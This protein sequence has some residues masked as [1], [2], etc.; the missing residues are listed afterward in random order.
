ME[1]G[2]AEA[3]IQRLFV[4]LPC[5][6]NPRIAAALDELRAAQQAPDSGVRVVHETTLH[7]TLKFLGATP[8]ELV[9]RI[10]DALDAVVQEQAAFELELAGAGFFHSALWL[11]V[12]PQPAL[13]KLAQRCNAAFAP[14][15]FKPDDK[16]YRPHVT[17]ARLKRNPGFDVKAWSQHLRGS[18]WGTLDARTVQLY[19]SETLP[20]GARYTV[21]H[22]VNMR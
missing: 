21:M 22:S 6:L 2:G 14:L 1:A 17:L 12:K 19:R 11:G 7:I 13:T 18:D 16:G 8:E 10:C 4:A 15:G 9:P 5:P 3:G 20:T